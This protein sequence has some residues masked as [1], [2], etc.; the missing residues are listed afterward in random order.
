MVRLR[1]LLDK[2]RT[3]SPRNT[4][5]LVDIFST[6]P[7]PHVRAIIL[8]RFKV[9]G[10]RSLKVTRPT[11]AE[12]ESVSYLTNGKAY[13]YKVRTWYANGGQVGII[14]MWFSDVNKDLTFKDKDQTLKA[15]DQDKYQTY[16]D[17][18][19]DKDQTPK[20]KDQTFKAK[21]EDED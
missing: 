3:K 1:V 4:K 17:K 16:K 11:N 8:T 19:K 21:D 9:G 15:K 5:I 7:S 14:I 13:K 20:D 2:S 10:Q 12:T 6:P 18:D